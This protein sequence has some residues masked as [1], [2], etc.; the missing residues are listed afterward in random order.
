MVSN[1]DINNFIV[2]VRNDHCIAPV[3][4]PAQYSGFMKR[5]ISFQIERWPWNFQIFQFPLG[6]NCKPS[7]RWNLVTLSITGVSPYFSWFFRKKFLCT[8]HILQFYG[9]NS[10]N[11][12]DDNS[13]C[14]SF[15]QTTNFA[16]TRGWCQYFAPVPWLA[17][18]IVTQGKSLHFGV[19]PGF[20]ILRIYFRLDKRGK[21]KHWIECWVER[22]EEIPHA[23]CWY[24]RRSPFQ[25]IVTLLLLYVTITL[26]VSDFLP[27]NQTKTIK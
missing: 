16:E 4:L 1:L 6:S 18:L 23:T 13:Q 21:A 15:A 25:L 11:D 9:Y 10:D 8:L 26:L 22:G 14:F 19:F 27:V 3:T 2:T 12:N 24:P 7:S 5:S 17:E 20:K